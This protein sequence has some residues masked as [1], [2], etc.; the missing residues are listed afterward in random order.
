MRD[1]SIQRIPLV[2]AFGTLMANTSDGG[3]PASDMKSYFGTSTIIDI[4]RR[5]TADEIIMRV[6]QWELDNKERL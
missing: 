4:I 6:H 1:K 2:N 3:M 5:F